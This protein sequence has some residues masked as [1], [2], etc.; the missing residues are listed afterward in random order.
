MAQNVN[1]L[2]SQFSDQKFKINGNSNEE[3]DEDEV[4]SERWS[5]TTNNAHNNI[6]NLQGKR[7]ISV[8]ESTESINEDEQ[9]RRSQFKVIKEFEKTMEFVKNASN[10][11]VMGSLPDP[12][13]SEVG[14]N[15][16]VR[17]LMVKL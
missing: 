8:N 14:L 4:E 16:V 6:E 10:L 13:E 15:E 5:V 2:K 11:K 3:A 17:N 7:M 1:E 12:Q 9:D